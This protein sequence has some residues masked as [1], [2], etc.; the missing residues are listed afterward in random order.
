MKVAGKAIT[1]PVE[2]PSSGASMIDVLDHVLDEGIVVDANVRVAVAGIELI[3]VE[4]IDVPDRLQ[5][6]SRGNI[7]IRHA[8]RADLALLDEV[9]H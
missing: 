1:F 2:K 4:R 9:N 3:T 7:E 6:M 8:D 5:R